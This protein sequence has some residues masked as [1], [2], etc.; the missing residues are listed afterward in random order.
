MRIQKPDSTKPGT[1]HP[2]LV[3]RVASSRCSV[4]SRRPW[5]TPGSVARALAIR[6]ASARAD[7]V[8]VRTFRY[9]TGISK[10]RQ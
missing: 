4:S 7:G 1:H 5:L 8:L 3:G 10:T 2:R 9:R 6:L